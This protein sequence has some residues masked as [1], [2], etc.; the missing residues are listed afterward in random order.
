M[1]DII[2]KNPL[3]TLGLYANATSSAIAGR[4][5]QLAAKLRSG[6]PTDT[7]ESLDGIFGA[8]ERTPESLAAARMAL[9]RPADRLEHT[10]FW[11]TEADAV[12]T[13][14][15]NALGQQDTALAKSIWEGSADSVSARHN[16]CVLLLTTGNIAEAHS[17]AAGLFAANARELC[18]LLAPGTAFGAP[19]LTA[20]Y[21]R[22]APAAPS[23]VPERKIVVK[24]RPAVSPR[25]TTP[26]PVTT[27]KPVEIEKPVVKV[28]LD[29]P[30]PKATDSPYNPQPE[31]RQVEKPAPPRVEPVRDEVLET[32]NYL[33]SRIERLRN[34][35]P[36][37]EECTRF[38]NEADSALSKL[39][40]TLGKTDQKA[41]TSW[42]D[43]C[44]GELMSSL[45]KIGPYQ[46]ATPQTAQAAALLT[47]ARSWGLSPEV[48]RSLNAYAARFH[49]SNNDTT[50][51]V[52]IAVAVI[53]FLLR[54]CS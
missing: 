43:G 20:L 47:R 48:L 4:S 9:G 26:P 7:A 39:R 3:R 37:L 46:R 21:R 33:N 32:I 44:A 16:L 27:D 1:H 2:K 54:A 19:E 35:N 18:A 53:I 41:Y 31:K 49:T 40:N 17:A 10:L 50:A 51:V 14:A 5:M 11:F 38:A 29:M 15:L 52:V 45:S 42:A 24:P 12:D 22:L 36:S 13:A 6:I 23:A 25:P 28:P 30:T 34:E 8:P